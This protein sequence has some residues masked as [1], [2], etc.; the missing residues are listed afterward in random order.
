MNPATSLQLK[1]ATIGGVLIAAS[2]LALAFSGLGFSAFWMAIA[3]GTPASLALEHVM[4]KRA[5]LPTLPEQVRAQYRDRE[6]SAVTVGLSLQGDMPLDAPEDIPPET[7]MDIFDDL[8]QLGQLVKD[9]AGAGGTVGSG[10]LR[11]AVL[12]LVRERPSDG[13]DLLERL[14]PLGFHRA[15]PGRM[16][17][18]LRALEQQGLVHSTWA[19]SSGEGRH[20]RIYQATRAGVAELHRQAEELVELDMNVN[21]FLNRYNEFLALRRWEASKRAGADA[22]GSHAPGSGAQGPDAPRPISEREQ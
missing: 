15:D 21:V 12:L 5:Q 10:F 11:I 22:P 13:Y 6:G 16:Y 4:L 1:A 17:R 7:P 19:P 14:R 2:G 18:V 9:Q 8:T 20:R 3:I